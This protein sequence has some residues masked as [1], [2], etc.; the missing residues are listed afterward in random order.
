MFDTSASYLAVTSGVTPDDP[1]LA[2]TRST[3]SQLDLGSF[4]LELGGQRWLVDLGLENYGAAGYFNQNRFKF[5]RARTEGHNTLAIS[6]TMQQPL[7]YANQAYAAEAA[8]TKF[9]STVTLPAWSFEILDMTPVYA[10]ARVTSVKR[11]IAFIKRTNVNGGLPWVQAV[12]QDEIVASTAV[13]VV[14]MFHTM[15]TVSIDSSG[16][17]ATFTQGGITMRGVI[18][19]PSTASWAK[20]TCDASGQTPSGQNAN[21]GCSN[22]IVRAASMQ[23]SVT[24]SVFFQLGTGYTAYPTPGFG[25]LS[26]WPLPVTK[27]S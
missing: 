25:P 24:I 21:T 5:Y 3:H 23:T 20:I 27:R 12:I 13:D 14:S 10:Y 8:Q 26:N 4:I 22:M 15:A 19:S 2:T 11:G 9:V 17:V 6:T 7:A 18:S 1:S 16:K